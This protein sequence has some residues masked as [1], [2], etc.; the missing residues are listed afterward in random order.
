MSASPIT[1]N[2][3]WEIALQTHLSSISPQHQH[4]LS[5]VTT[6]EDIVS[7][8]ERAQRNSSNRKVNKLLDAVNRATAPL[9]D[10]QTVADVLVQIDGRIG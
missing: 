6:P 10:F 5:S 3:G 4:T 8:L 7:I 2:T 1:L 9:R